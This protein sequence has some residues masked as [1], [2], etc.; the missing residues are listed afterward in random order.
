MARI[1]A[2]TNK[3]ETFKSF[4]MRVCPEGFTVF[5]RLSFLLTFLVKTRVDIL[6]GVICLTYFAWILHKN[7]VYCLTS[8]LCQLHTSLTS[9]SKISSFWN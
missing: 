5:Q 8:R 4:S 6:K 1:L 7:Q 2:T 9:K 3:V